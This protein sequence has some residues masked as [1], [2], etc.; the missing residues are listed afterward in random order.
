MQFVKKEYLQLLIINC[1]TRDFVHREMQVQLKRQ[2]VKRYLFAYKEGKMT[3]LSNRLFHDNDKMILFSNLSMGKQC[4][5][6]KCKVKIQILL[7]CK[8][9]KK[10]IGV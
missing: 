1:N 9:I 4:N 6:H 8:G 7:R 10:K 3:L 2:I 5:W